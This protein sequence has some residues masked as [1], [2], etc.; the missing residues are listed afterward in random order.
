MR[1]AGRFPR[2]A[3]AATVAG[4]ALA[5]FLPRSAAA[6]GNDEDAAALRTSQA[7]IGRPT[8][9][10]RFVDQHGRAFS[11]AGLRGRPVVLSLVYTN[12]YAICS[13]LTLQL[14]EAVRVAHQ[15]LG[16]GRFAVVTV[17]FDVEHD[18]PARMRAYGRDRGIDDADWYFLSGDAPT[19]RALADEVGFSWRPSPAGFDHV[20]QATLLDRNGTVVRQLYGPDFAPPTLVEPLKRLV[21]GAG[22]ERLSVSDVITRVRLLCS[23]YD[24]ASGRYRFDV[25]MLA[26]ALPPLLVLAIA[27]AGILLASRRRR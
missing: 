15:T 8:G 23:I 13:G 25:S 6:S 1:V 20:T 14:R 19:V 9:D 10:H 26:A 11:L 12:C 24:P 7:A 3:V 5:T 27:S 18:T 21:L 4:L 22:L 2:F 16:A 17:G